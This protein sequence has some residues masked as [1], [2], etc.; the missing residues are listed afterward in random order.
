MISLRA[1]KEK[2]NALRSNF[3][4]ELKNNY[5]E[6]VKIIITDKDDHFLKI[7]NDFDQAF[8]KL[9]QEGSRLRSESY[10]ALQQVNVI[11]RRK[12]KRAQCSTN[13]S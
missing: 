9:E 1:F 4:L 7:L 6:L 8:D 11:D 13:V 3:Q 10:I 5:E 2:A 12:L